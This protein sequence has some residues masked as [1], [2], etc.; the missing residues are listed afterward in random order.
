MSLAH[1]LGWIAFLI[2]FAC[3]VFDELA[4][5]LFLRLFAAAARQ[6]DSEKATN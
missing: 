4:L 6:I 1:A 5:K 2:G 3:R